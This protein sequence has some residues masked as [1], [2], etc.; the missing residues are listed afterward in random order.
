MK[1]DHTLSGHRGVCDMQLFISIFVTFLRHNALYT[2]VL[3]V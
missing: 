3:S 2:P 1:E